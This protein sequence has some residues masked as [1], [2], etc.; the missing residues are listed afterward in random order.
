MSIDKYQMI[1]TA[2]FNFIYHFSTL[3]LNFL[4]EKAIQVINSLKKL[5]PVPHKQINTKYQSIYSS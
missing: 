4:T 5:L 2:D 1:N 3:T